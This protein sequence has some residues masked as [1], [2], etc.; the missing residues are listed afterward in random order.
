MQLLVD[1]DGW[2]RLQIFSPDLRF[3]SAEPES[4]VRAP[5]WILCLTKRRYNGEVFKAIQ[6]E[7]GEEIIS[8]TPEWRS[9]LADLRALDRAD[10]LVCQACRQ[11]MR[12]K[13]GP[14]RRPHFAHKHL[15]G[16]SFGSESPA[17][18]A[19][20]AVL[21][22]RLV[23]LFPGRVE[24]EL[25][26]EDSGLPRAVDAWVNFPQGGFAFWVVDATLKLEARDAIRQAFAQANRAVIWVLCARMLHLDPK[27]HTWLRLSPTERDFLRATPYDEI[28][29]ES[30]ISGEDF[31]QSLHYLDAEAGTLFT[32]RSLERVHAPNVFAGRKLSSPLAQVRVNPLTADLTHPGE[33]S[34][35]SA[36][37][38][39]RG[40]RVERIQRFLKPPQPDSASPG[41]GQG[42]LAPRSTRSPEESRAHWQAE[43][44]RPTDPYAVCVY[45]AQSTEDWWQAWWDGDIHRCKCRACLEKGLG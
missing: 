29:K 2:I 18:L 42:W 12:L 6:V 33:E 19:A 35:L 11:P 27:N 23:E 37:R 44:P 7:T 39:E 40:R 31:G 28:G 41:G 15:K 1:R 43:T 20:R 10:Q 25:N 36:S 30:R 22:E 24:L 3:I 13:A 16:C 34:Q 38:A 8:L 32:F 45:C 5:S 21:Y 17:V 14:R 26:L 4:T 9:R